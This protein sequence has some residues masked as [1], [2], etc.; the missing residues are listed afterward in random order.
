MAEL[1]PWMPWA[2]AD[3]DVDGARQWMNVDFG[4]AHPFVIVAT[5]DSIVG[6]T[7]LNKIDEANRT[8]N[9][10][11][12]VRSDRT[13]HGIATAVVRLVARY[14]I[15]V[16]E[17]ERLEIMMS[18]RNEA[19]RRVAARAGAT[20]EGVRRGALHLHEQQHDTHVFSFVTGDEISRPD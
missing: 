9:L 10:G 12:W 3:Y 17:Y 16:C 11:Y 1:A 4:D 19:S 18:T 14:G 20:Y 15:E 2:T 6:S 8:A 7:G 13:G 5:D